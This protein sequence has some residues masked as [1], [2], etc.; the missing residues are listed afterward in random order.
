MKLLSLILAI[1][2]AVLLGLQWWPELAAQQEFLTNSAFG[3]AILLSVTTALCLRENRK[4]PGKPTVAPVAAAVLQPMTPT[5]SEIDGVEAVGL[6]SALQ[7]S[8]RLVDFLMDDISSFQ[9]AQVGA[10]A[11]I[12]HQGCRSVLEQSFAISPVCESAEGAII[13]VPVSYRGDEYRLSGSL[14][15]NPPFAGTVLHRGWKT[16]H[17][18]L[19]RTVVPDG[20]LPN[21]APAE[22]E[23]AS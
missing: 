10:A 11:R 22:V 8:G 21:I 23:V 5:A 9:D 16:A 12:V 15:G 18:K 2:V 17:V 6:L 3:T 14:S 4:V 19:P 1:V 20:L 13:S 7:E